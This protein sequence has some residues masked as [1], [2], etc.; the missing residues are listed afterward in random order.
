MPSVLLHLGEN[1]Q[2]MSKQFG[3]RSSCFTFRLAA[4]MRKL[5][6]ALLR[7]DSCLVIFSSCLQD[8]NKLLSV[9]FS[10][11]VIYSEVTWHYSLIWEQDFSSSR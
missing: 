3:P 9:I 2:V 11:L 1:A 6:G 5:L 7:T 10:G 8:D 4:S